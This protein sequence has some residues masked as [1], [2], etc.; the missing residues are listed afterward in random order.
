MQ[1]RLGESVSGR[2]RPEENLLLTKHV[3]AAGRFA[4]DAGSTPAASTICGWWLWRAIGLMVN[5]GSFR[6]LPFF[7]YPLSF[8]GNICE[9][10]PTNK[11]QIGLFL[12]AFKLPLKWIFQ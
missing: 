10:I 4:K 6:D 9:V 2:N 1:A 5:P 8:C 3:V 12:A 11:G 7:I